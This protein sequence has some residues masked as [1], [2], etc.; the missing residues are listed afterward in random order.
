M[1]VSDIM[2]REVVFVTPD[3]PVSEVARMLVK[4]SVSGVP[5]VENGKVIGIVTEEDLIMRDAIID[6][7]HFFGFFESVFY[8]VRKHEFDEE[9][10]KI[11]ATE[12]RDLM[13]R[14]VITVS[15]DASVQEL[16]TLMVKKEVNPVPV[17]DRSGE[18]V[19]IVSRSDL[20]RLMVAEEEQNM[21]V[22]PPTAEGVNEPEIDTTHFEQHKGDR[23]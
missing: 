13:N 16:A 2:T 11:L 18:L 9:M 14:K 12:A 23:Q 7:P 22:E 17:I 5:V 10:H 3:A 19:G 20:V 21:A 6:M 8:P 1:N 15:Q 4:H